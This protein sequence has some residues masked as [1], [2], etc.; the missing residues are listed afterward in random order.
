M[1][2]SASARP[3]CRR[4]YDRPTGS[5]H[6]LARRAG[7]REA[8]FLADSAPLLMC[9]RDGTPDTPV[10]NVLRAPYCGRGWLTWSQQLP[11]MRISCRLRWLEGTFSM[12]GVLSGLRRWDSTID[13]ESRSTTFTRLSA[14]NV[15]W[16]GTRQRDWCTRLGPQIVSQLVAPGRGVWYR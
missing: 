3:S 14:C 10:E 2:T 5:R 12:G 4:L 16:V 9:R 11:M 6:L 7:R 15:G 8:I 13:D 1:A